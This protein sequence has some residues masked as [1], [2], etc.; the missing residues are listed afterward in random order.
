MATCKIIL[1]EMHPLQK[2][3]YRE[4]TQFNILMCGRGWGKT[5]FLEEV[6]ELHL[7]DHKN[8]TVGWFAPTNKDMHEQMLSIRK[9]MEP[10]I[11]HDDKQNN[12]IRLKNGSRIDFW[13][14]VDPDSGRGREYTMVCIDEASKVSQLE[15]SWEQAILGTLRKA[16]PPKVWI[17]GTPQGRNYFYTLWKRGQD[18]L[19]TRW[20]S[21]KFASMGNPY[22]NHQVILDAKQDMSPAIFA[23]EF[24]ATPV[25]DV[26]NPF[27]DFR[28]CI[29]PELSTKPAVIYGF[30]P[31]RAVDYS[32]LVGLDEDGGV[33]Y[34]DHW[35][36]PW[37][38]TIER[39]VQ[40]I[41]DVPCIMDGTGIGDPLHSQLSRETQ[42]Y[43]ESFKYNRGSKQKL[44]EGLASCIG[45]KMVSYPDGLIVN[46]LETFQYKMTATGVT[47]DC[48][49]GLHDDVV[50]ALAL[51]NYWLIQHG[52]RIEIVNL[53]APP[54]DVEKQAKKELEQ[55]AK[56]QQEQTDVEYTVQFQS[57]GDWMQE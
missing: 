26:G 28:S 45:R 49:S 23:Q 5:A 17:V 56:V 41:G 2:L 11:L 37:D 54:P 30:D 40:I 20:K 21:W 55:E 7:L 42:A 35:K 12:I 6:A 33:T 52:N 19:N 24:E 9:K 18:D 57:I 32:A 25:D 53:A 10:L 16:K 22:I 27:G 13:S 29:V 4:Q 43:V 38:K 31:A 3:V 44:M 50:N 48:P 39:V 15:Y 34:V 14:L 46:E 47:Y 36:L 1:N 51:A 8:A